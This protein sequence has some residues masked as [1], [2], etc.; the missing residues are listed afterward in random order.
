MSRTLTILAAAGA[1]ALTAAGAAPALAQNAAAET[2]PTRAE[3]QADL[4]TRFKSMDG[5]GDGGIDTAE[6]NAAN[7]RVAK[8]AATLV[9]QRIEAEFAQLDADKNGQVSLAEF[10]AAAPTPTPTPAATT[11][12]R[13]DSSKDGKINL[14][15]YSANMLTAYDQLDTNKDGKL[16]QQEQQA[17]S[18]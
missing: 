3:L 9:A 4:G 7:D 16:S 1:A 8:Q 10:K 13:L 15:E 5:N 2:P 17:E 18:R 12:Q 14:A 6:I 11:L